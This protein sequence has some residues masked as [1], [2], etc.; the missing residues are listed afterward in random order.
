MEVLELGLEKINGISEIL[1][2][3]S[4]GK[5]KENY[6]ENEFLII[7]RDDENYYS[8]LF[9]FQEFD[10]ILNHSVAS[11]ESVSVVR[12]AEKFEKKN[13]VDY[14]KLDGRINLNQ[15]YASYADGYS[16]VVNG[17]HQYNEGINNLVN[18]LRIDLSANIGANM[19]LTPANQK[20][21]A[22][23][24][25]THDVFVLQLHGEKKWNIYENS[26][27][28]IPPVNSPQPNFRKEELTL[29]KEVTLKAGDFMYLPRGV[30]HD[31]YTEDQS[32][33]HITIGVYPIQWMDFFQ[34]FI[35]IIGYKEIEL[36]KSLPLGI[37]GGSDSSQLLEQLKM[38]SDLVSSHLLDQ[39][40]VDATL[41]Q[42]FDEHRKSID[43][44]SDSNFVNIDRVHNINLGT[45]LEQRR[46]MSCRVYS[47]KLST[48]IV[49][50]GN[51][52]KGPIRLLSTFQFIADQKGGFSVDDIPNVNDKN[53][54]KIAKRLI[55]GGLLRIVSNN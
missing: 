20:A 27:F 19:Y 46:N 38:K 23:H 12:N 49:F 14:Q 36:R 39:R 47:E 11:G 18:S 34:K 33:L 24:Y 22:S 50:A 8:S 45:T 9:T 48:T 15:L 54:I 55:R 51:S 3:I 1:S 31:A 26:Q 37:L 29:A 42:L 17:V 4:L 2:P 5:F 40:F 16:I 32:S 35:Q 10:R 43:T 28:E 30:P 53:K 6:W 41:T 21:F 13:F 7:K 25:D 52:V 44:N